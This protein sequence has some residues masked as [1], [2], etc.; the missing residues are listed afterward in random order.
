MT[1]KPQKAERREALLRAAVEVM[2]EHGI[3][4]SRIA[5]IAARAGISP[6]HVL[7]YFESKAELFLQALRTVER[8]LR[9]DV[10]THSAGL[11]FSAKFEYLLQAAAP[12]AVGDLRLLLWL[13]AWE[14]A[15]RDADVA[16]Q[17]Q[18]LED[19]WLRMLTDVL[20]EG[21]DAGE[22]TVDDLDAFVLRYSAL[23]DGLTIQVV[24]GS[25][26]LDRETMLTICRDV[27]RAELGWDPDGVSGGRR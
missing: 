26:H 9:D 15:S 13:E 11:P 14:L 20:A 7:Y 19:E 6:G 24:I 5:D 25:P 3:S 22:L 1:T 16:R 17:V 8:D 10:R 4:Q 21:R 2:A 12:R 23:I 18:E 27:V